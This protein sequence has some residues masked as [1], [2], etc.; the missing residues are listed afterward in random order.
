MKVSEYNRI[1][2]CAYTLIVGLETGKFIK[3]RVV[4]KV[5]KHILLS[6]KDSITIQGERKTLVAKSLGCGIYE[7][8]PKRVNNAKD[9]HNP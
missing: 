2:S 5:W 3:Y 1:V 4:K 6:N 9:I 7:I 8:T